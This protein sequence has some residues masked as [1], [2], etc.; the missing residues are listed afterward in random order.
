[1][2]TEH[3]SHPPNGMTSRQIWKN[4][5]QPSLNRWAFCNVGTF[6]PHN[7][8][9]SSIT[10]IYLTEN[11]VDILSI[12][13]NTND[14]ISP[15][16]RTL[17]VAEALEYLFADSLIVIKNDV[18]LTEKY[19]G[20]MHPETPHILFSVSKPFAG[21]LIACLL[22]DHLIN[23]ENDLLVHYLPEYKNTAFKDVTIRHLL[24]MQSGVNFNNLRDRALI[25]RACGFAPPK[26]NE[27][28]AL[29]LKAPHEK[30]PFRNKNRLQFTKYRY[31]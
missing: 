19:Y 2:A 1:M 15:Q 23:S 20:C 6:I 22:D 31:A 8:I 14:D 18:I 13:F 29:L 24:D 7:I 30:I 26:G 12:E 25:E 4:F 3:P 16:K 17:L 10:P 28:I 21:A 5:Q 9:H 27:N 11:Y